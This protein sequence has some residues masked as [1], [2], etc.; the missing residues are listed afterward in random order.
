MPNALLLTALL[1][2]IG[3]ETEIVRGSGTWRSGSG[4]LHGFSALRA[5]VT[6][7][8][9]S[10]TTA[11]SKVL[12]NAP[13]VIGAWETG[14]LLEESPSDIRNLPWMRWHTDM[15]IED[16]YMLKPE[17]ID[18]LEDARNFPEMLDALRNRSHIFNNLI[19]ESWC[20][21]PY[22]MIDKT[23]AYIY[24]LH[25][26]RILKETHAA[27][28]P[29]VVVKKSL[30]SL[31]ESWGKRKDRL[32]KYFYRKTYSNVERMIRKY[33]N[34]IMVVNWDDVAPNVESV[35]QE[36][37][38]FIGLKWRTD[39]LKMTNLK[40]KFAIYGKVWTDSIAQWEWNISHHGSFI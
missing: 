28:V 2:F 32:P 25:F 37:F 31:R 13:C 5:I 7:L 30:K 33:P 16:M 4:R 21:K 14:F 23:P 27:H 24:K 17:D 8:E 35:M 11:I 36:V 38:Q 29:V 40:K 15:N 20:D 6:G 22:Q 1:G 19:D 3:A 9:H 26:E 18:A 10:G 34:R 39:Y 12:F